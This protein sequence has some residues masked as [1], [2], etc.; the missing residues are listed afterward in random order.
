MADAPLLPEQT[1]QFAARRQDWIGRATALVNQI[2][3]WAAAEG[4]GAERHEKQIVERLL[5]QYSVPALILRVPGGELMVNPIGLHI[6]GG[7]G[8]VD[9]EALPTLSRVKLIGSTDGWQI[10]TDSN[11]PLRIPWTRQSFVQLVEDLLR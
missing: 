4:W 3:E 5:G 7:D 1:S 11:I 10:W 6:A 2:A 9:L 8:R